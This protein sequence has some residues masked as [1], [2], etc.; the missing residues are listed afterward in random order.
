MNTDG[1]GATGIVDDQQMITIN[2]R[3]NYITKL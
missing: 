1:T 3:E 2:D